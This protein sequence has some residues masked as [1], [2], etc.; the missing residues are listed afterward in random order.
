MNINAVQQCKHCLA[1]YEWSELRDGACWECRLA[2]RPC[3]PTDE[4][5][6]VTS[7]RYLP[8]PSEGATGADAS[9]ERAA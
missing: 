1:E 8:R 6:P 9:S 2:L 5:A 3:T 7:G 4:S